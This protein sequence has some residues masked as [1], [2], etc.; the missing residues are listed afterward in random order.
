MSVDCGVCALKILRSKIKDKVLCVYVYLLLM[1]MYYTFIVYSV[2][3]LLVSFNLLCH[4]KANF[5]VI[6]LRQ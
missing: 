6:H 3:V 1:F 2:C 5:C 4:R